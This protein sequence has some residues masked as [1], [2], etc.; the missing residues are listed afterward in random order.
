[1]AVKMKKQLV[2]ILL[3]L[4][5]LLLSSATL[6]QT[7]LPD[8]P[9]FDTAITLVTQSD[10]E[11]LQAML[12][13]LA[14]S[15]GLTPIAEGVPEE[16][17]NLRIEEPKPFR[18]IWSILLQRYNL[19]Y[20]LL[21]NDVVVIGSSLSIADFKPKS[22][23]PLDVDTVQTFYQ[24]QNDKDVNQVA[25]LIKRLVPDILI[26]AL[27]G[28]QSVLVR[29]TAEQQEQVLIIVKQYAPAQS[30]EVI[31]D[32]ELRVYLLSNAKASELA[33]VLQDSGVSSTAEK[34]A[35][36]P[37][38]GEVVK[39]AVSTK[40]VQF[41][42]VAEE[43][44]NSL[45]I[46]A[47]VEV[48]E[49][50][51]GLLE[52]IDVPRQ[53]VNVQLR[54]QE[55]T[56]REATKLGIN[57]SGG[58]GNFGINLLDTGLKFIFDAQQAVSGL[59]L[60]AVLDTLES[61]GLSRKVDDVNITIL[62]NEEANL[63]SGGRIEIQFQGADGSI[64][65]RTLEYG[66]LVSMIPRITN[67]GNVIVAVNAEVSDLLTP[68]TAGEVPNRL[69]FSER[70]TNSSVTISPGQTVVLGGL[71]QNS[72]TQT[73]SGVPVLSDIPLLG[74]LFSQTELADNNTELLLILTADI[75]E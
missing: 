72:F 6:A 39:D 14:L 67:D 30:E 34:D 54:I 74:N 20:A 5:T 69:D 26:E 22:D 13:S 59:N 12:E 60:G 53:Q 21:E 61:Q 45:I 17:V 24:I 43:S 75:I 7:P 70:K 2:P 19:D 65:F 62:N 50:I 47:P 41:S 63:K 58:L 29:G 71:F 33:L 11:D 18:Q 15:V 1:M 64:G 36:N 8:D 56:S 44:S 40:E 25:D 55:I 66:V 23:L 46:N 37:D 38:G 31:I 16:L 32:K 48:H 28:L 3:V 9:K 35:I 49:R 68:F 27:P 52:Q 51:A 57:L 42:V 4:S 73:Q 10:G